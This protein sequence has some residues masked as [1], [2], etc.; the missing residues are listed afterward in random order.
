MEMSKRAV[1]KTGAGS[2]LVLKAD[3]A[4]LCI[5]TKPANVPS[6]MSR[7]KL[8]PVMVMGGTFPLVSCMCKQI[9]HHLPAAKTL[10]P[11]LQFSQGCREQ[12][13]GK[14]DHAHSGTA[15]K[16]SSGQVCTELR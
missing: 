2:V 1:S 16:A 7:G 12:T 5:A 10:L 4:A 14:Y 8:T 13:E 9:E 3:I 15:Q 6:T 11:Y